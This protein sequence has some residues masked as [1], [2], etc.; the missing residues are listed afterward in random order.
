MIS[1]NILESM[2]LFS[3]IGLLLVVYA[4]IIND[5]MKDTYY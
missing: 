4:I 3:I 5:M 2:I 1:S